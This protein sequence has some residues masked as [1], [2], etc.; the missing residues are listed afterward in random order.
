MEVL[1]VHDEV[2]HNFKAANEVLPFLI[3]TFHPQSILDVG[4]GIGTWLKVAKDMGVKEVL[5]VDGGYTNRALLK[6][7]ADEFTEQDLRKQFSLARKFD[8][9]FCL[10]VAE[11]LPATAA[12]DLIA[13]LCNHSDTVIFSA[14]IP[15]Q[16]GQHHINEQWP[17]YWTALFAQNGFQFYDILRPVFWNNAD[18]EFWY[19]Q[20]MIVFSKKHPAS[21][22]SPADRKVPLPYVHPDLFERKNQE[23]SQL[24][25]ELDRIKAKPGVNSSFNLFLKALKRKIF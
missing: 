8:L 9:V 4:C 2:V 6:I 11:H 10:E 12:P 7:S 1:Y 21:D 15:G 14:A 22:S 3:N 5:G 23:I 18:V 16:G 13:S 17:A 19:K 24:N 25:T 20:N